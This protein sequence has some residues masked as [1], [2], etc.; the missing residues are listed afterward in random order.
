M[1]TEAQYDAAIKAHASIA[2]KSY[3]E[4]FEA[5]DELDAASDRVRLLERQLPSTN[6][7]NS[8]A[9]FLK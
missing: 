8:I 6:N 4:G 1:N 2:S 3:D 9:V 5:W 7:T